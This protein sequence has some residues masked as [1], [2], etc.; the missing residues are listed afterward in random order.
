M[1]IKFWG[2]RG[3]LP[4]AMTADIV[5]QKLITAFNS[6]IG[7]Q[8]DTPELIEDFVCNKLPFQTA[9]TFGGHSSSV[10]IDCGASEF[11]LLDL[12]SG[13]R[14]FG[15]YAMKE[16]GGKG[17]YHIF[18]SHP[19]WDHIMGFPFFVPAYIPGNRITIYGGHDSL[20]D[21]FA[22]QQHTPF[23]PVDF[24]TLSAEIDFICLKP[25]QFYDIAGMTVSTMKQRH[26][27]D[28]YSYR[29]EKDDKIFVYAT[30]AEH[31]L[32]DINKLKEVSCFFQDADA[33]VFDAMYSLADALSVREEWGHSNNMIGVELCQQAG[34]KRLCLFHH[35]P[36]YDD[37]KLMDIHCAT[38]RFEE[39]VRTNSPTEIIT[40]YD[41]LEL[42]L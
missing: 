33:V 7:I 9:G 11:V 32:D 10:Q 28:S 15:T 14:P 21:V 5:R 17:R 42:L 3:S 20:Y 18:L 31:K 6:A 4:V 23:F 25:G 34:V 12:G 19:H 16:S 22:T 37:E 36:V 35:E 40:A 24:T 1:R 13:A 39:I 29:F 2:T 26:Q 41:G 30:D 27:G 8:L 38:I